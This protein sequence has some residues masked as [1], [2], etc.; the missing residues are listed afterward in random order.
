MATNPGRVAMVGNSVVKLVTFFASFFAVMYLVAGVTDR[1]ETLDR[2]I[3]LLVGCG[4]V[5]AAFTM[6]EWQSGTNV[7]NDLQRVFPPLNFRPDFLPSTPGRGDRPRAYA[8]AQHAI[9]LGAALV[10]LLPLTVYLWR[11]TGRFIWMAGGAL[12]VMGALATGSRTAVIMLVVCLVMFFRYKRRATVRMLPYLLPM[13]IVLQVA[14]PGTLGTFRASF[15]P[16]QGLVNDELAGEGTG[17]GRLQDVG[18]S[19]QEWGQSPLFGQGFGTRLTSLQDDALVGFVNAR[20]LDNQWLSSLLELGILGVAAL[21][22]LLVRAL[23]RLKRR[24]KSDDSDYGWL[25]TAL[26]TS[27]AAFSFGMFTY[28]AFSFIQ[29]TLLLFIF[30]GLATVALRIGPEP[31]EVE[32]EQERR[33]TATPRAPRVS[34]PA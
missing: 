24:A 32:E 27:I 25:L 18:P 31:E 3:K 8:S 34:V 1:R 15:F 33:A 17:T 4:I 29:V 10:M 30:L 28:D 23:R 13:F 7:F 14:M 21:V 11:R 9:A 12:L 20:I 16:Q 19:L 22:W 5:V 6:Y 2:L 26:A